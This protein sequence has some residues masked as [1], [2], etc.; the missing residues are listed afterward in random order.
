MVAA[1]ADLD[2]RD[3]S[4]GTP[5]HAAWTNRRAIVEELVQSGA[6]PLARDERGRV[7]DPTSCA[8]WN[9]VAYIRLAFPSEFTLC[10]ELGE[11]VNARDSD[12]NTP[13]HMAAETVNPRAVRFLLEAG[14]D[15]NAA[16]HRGATPLHI[17]VGNE[18]VQYLSML[19]EAGVDISARI[20]RVPTPL[21]IPE[22]IDGEEVL[23]ALLDAGAD[24]MTSLLEAG[25]DID[26]GAGD[27]GT[28]LLHVIAGD[29]WIPM[30]AI[31]ESAVT[32][33]LAAGVAVNAVTLLSRPIVTWLSR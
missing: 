10:L 19:H 13:L 3:N 8:N 26:A 6:D 14:A 11:D 1:G 9:T 25:A 5:L 33:L 21:H 23:T 29:R 2:A 27:Y 15:L 30:G 18:G 22:G 17:N 4:G 7:A 24:I 31:N 12:G 16:N 20:S 28:P 32:A